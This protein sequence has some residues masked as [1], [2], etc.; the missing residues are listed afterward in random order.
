MTKIGNREHLSFM[1]KPTEKPPKVNTTECQPLIMKRLKGLVVYKRLYLLLFQLKTHVNPL[2]GCITPYTPMG[3]FIH[4]PPP[5]PRSDWANNFGKPWWKNEKYCIGILSSRTR[6][7]RI[8]NTLTLREQIIE[9]GSPHLSFYHCSQ[10]LL[11]SSLFVLLTT[12]SSSKSFLSSRICV[13]AGACLVT[14]VSLSLLSL[15]IVSL[16]T[17]LASFPGSPFAPTG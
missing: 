1:R 14:L 13:S 7:I 5:C 6:R 15:L 10:T 2:T 16:A 8:I 11:V 4:V 9:V 3:R 17:P 12:D